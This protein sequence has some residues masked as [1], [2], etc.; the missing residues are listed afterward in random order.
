MHTNGGSFFIPFTF[1]LKKQNPLFQQGHCGGFNYYDVIV[2]AYSRERI[3]D[4]HVYRSVK[5]ING[6]SYLRHPNYNDTADPRNDFTLL[7]LANPVDTVKPVVLND[8]SSLPIDGSLLNAIGLGDTTGIFLR[9][10]FPPFLQEVKVPKVSDV[11]C[12]QQLGASRYF[13]KNMLC[14]GYT[15]GGKDACQ[16]DSGGPL[17]DT[18]GNQVGLTSWGDGCAD[19]LSPGVYSRVSSATS[20]IRQSICLYSQDKPSYCIPAPVPLGSQQAKLRITIQMD[21]SPWEIGYELRQTNTN[22]VLIN[23]VSG[24]WLVPYEL[25]LETVIV[26]SG[27]SLNFTL[28]DT[29]GNGELALFMCIYISNFFY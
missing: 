22:T 8:N 14:A 16:G 17:L 15:D 24:S 9:T 10:T 29:G 23:K 28:L 3:Y 18:N 6:L 12:S 5:A 20:W 27:M 2:N 13:P 25:V 1:L 21:Q 26:D 11:I 4:G 7:I 19:S